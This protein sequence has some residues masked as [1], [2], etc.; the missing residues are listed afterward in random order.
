M[1][2]NELR[3]GEE[4]KLQVDGEPALKGF[5]SAIVSERSLAAEFFSNKE[6]LTKYNG[7]SK[8]KRHEVPRHA[9]FQQSSN[10]F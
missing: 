5:M 8:S 10:V 3:I 6:Y 1:M 7:T 9:L 4:V 2:K